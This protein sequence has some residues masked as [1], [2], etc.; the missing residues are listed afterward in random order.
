MGDLE[1]SI[2]PKE[3]GGDW[4]QRLSNYKVSLLPSEM[5]SIRATSLLQ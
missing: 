3:S 1:W 2:T 4:S 5:A